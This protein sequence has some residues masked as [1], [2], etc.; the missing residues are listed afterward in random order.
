[1][2]L[3]SYN[4][5]ALS[6]VQWTNDNIISSNFEL[7][8]LQDQTSDNRSWLDWLLDQTSDNR[9]WLD[10]LQDQT[11]DSRLRLKVLYHTSFRNFLMTPP[12]PWRNMFPC[13]TSPHFEMT[14]KEQ[15][16]SIYF[17]LNLFQ[18]W[19]KVE[20]LFSLN[21]K[22]FNF[23]CFFLLKLLHVKIQTLSSICTLMLR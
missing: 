22:Q 12:P 10:C 6:L 14:P 20:N 2:I 9:L 21:W 19:N 7:D 17:L 8:W 5:R 13:K 3:T 15:C 4:T 23:A 18:I 11:R 16:L 1:M